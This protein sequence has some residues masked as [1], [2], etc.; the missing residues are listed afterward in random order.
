MPIEN[1][2]YKV[3]SHCNSENITGSASTTWNFYEQFWETWDEDDNYYCRDCC[4]DTS[5][6]DL[7]L[8]IEDEE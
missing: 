1:K 5:V 7:Y 8:Q 2:V 4:R 3:C 6:K